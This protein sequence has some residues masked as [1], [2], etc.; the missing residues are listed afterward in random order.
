M[1]SASDQVPLQVRTPDYLSTAFNDSF[2]NSKL[3]DMS[4]IPHKRYHRR[5]EL[6]TSAPYKGTTREG[7]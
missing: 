1:R 3:W 2:A 5:A 6:P 7:L 4:H